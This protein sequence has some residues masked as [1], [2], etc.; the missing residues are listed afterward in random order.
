MLVAGCVSMAT[1]ISGCLSSC[2]RMSNTSR[3][4][5]RR[6][7]SGEVWR[8]SCAASSFSSVSDD[9]DK[10]LFGDDALKL[11]NNNK[12]K[13][14]AAAASKNVAERIRVVFE[15]LHEL[16]LPPELRGRHDFVRSE[17]D[18]MN[19]VE[20]RIQHSQREG[21]FENLSG[22]GKPLEMVGNPHADPDEDI[23]Y[24]VLAKNGFAPEWVE[25]NKDI[26]FRIWRWR[27][28]LRLAWQQQQEDTQR[29]E[30]EKQQKWTTL[31]M[32]FEEELQDVNRKVLL[33]IL[34]T[35]ILVNSQTLH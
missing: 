1:T 15:R 10:S 11:G 22:K 18:L 23:A 2:V 7:I 12:T 30:C 6:M 32:Q 35:C 14:K 9:R 21:D 33:N 5:C 8:V 31:L 24:R 25:L 19:V 17:A 4:I 29:D 28:A 27:A 16:R 20:Q 34:Y 3:R 26:R 13:K